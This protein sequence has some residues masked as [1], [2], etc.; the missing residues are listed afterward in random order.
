MASRLK[1]THSP[2]G[3]SACGLRYAQSIPRAPARS[4]PI[5]AC[6]F[7]R[8]GRGSIRDTCG[9]VKPDAGVGSRVAGIGSPDAGERSRIHSRRDSLRRGNAKAAGFLCARG[10]CH[11]LPDAAFILPPAFSPVPITHD[12]LSSSPHPAPRPGCGGV[13]PSAAL[14]G[15]RAAAARDAAGS[16]GSRR[17]GPRN[18]G[19]SGGTARPGGT[20]PEAPQA[21]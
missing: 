5:R 17:A 11:S 19:A 20:G 7:R 3:R 8:E 14:H 9:R 12:S 18:T 4:I 1:L 10:S 21:A 2:P 6:R 13:R 15:V 16:P